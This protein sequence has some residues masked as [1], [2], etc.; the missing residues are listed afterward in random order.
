MSRHPSVTVVV[1]CTTEMPAAAIAGIRAQKRVRPDLVVVRLAGVSHNVDHEV[2]LADDS[3]TIPSLL[4]LASGEFIVLHHP[5]HRSLPDRV[6]RQLECLERD[7][8]SG[9]A[10]GNA[11]VVNGDTVTTWAVADGS[12]ALHERRLVREHHALLGAT[13]MIRR[14]VLEEAFRHGVTTLDLAFWLWAAT[15]TRTRH[16]GDGALIQVA[17]TDAPV[18]TLPGVVETPRAVTDALR[19]HVARRPLRDLVP[20]LDWP[21]LHPAAAERAALTRLAAIIDARPVAAPGLADA[22]RDRAGRVPEAPA[23]RRTRGRLLMT[24]YGFNDSGG[25]TTI[26]RLAA[27][28]LVRRGW[29]VTVF[30]AATAQRPDLGPY[31]TDEWEEDGVRLVG[32]FNRPH[33]FG[34]IGNPDREVDDPAITAAFDRV[35]QRVRPDVAHLHNLHNLGAGLLDV[36]SAHGV[37]AHFTTHNYWLLCPRTYLFGDDLRLCDGPAVD[38]AICASCVGSRDVQGHRRRFLGIRDRFTRAI[39]SCHAVSHAVR[40]N[41]IAHGYDPSHLDVV[42]Q[43]VPAEDEAWETVGRHRSPGRVNPDQLTVGFV[44]SVY[45][46]KGAHVLVRAAQQVRGDL[47]VRIHGEIPAAVA[48]QLLEIDERGC[49]ELHGAFSP[50]ELPTILQD[51]DVAALPSVWWDCAPL[52]AGEC[53]AAGVPVLAPRMG[54]LAEAIRDGVD[55]L[56]FEGA[57]HE[58]LAAALTRLVSEADLLPRLQ[59]GIEP[60]RGFATWIDDLEAAYAGMRPGRVDQADNA[61]PTAVRWVGD[62]QTHS[63]LAHI[64]REVCAR[65]EEDPSVNLQIVAMD[66]DR[67]PGPLPH[68]PEVEVRHSWPPRFD[69]HG[70]GRLALIQPWEY[71][72]IPR[73]WLEPLRNQVDELWVPSEFVRTMYLQAGVPGDRVVVVPNGVDLDLLDPS[74]PKYVPK[75]LREDATRFLFLGGVIGRKGPDVLLEAWARAFTPDDAV[76]LIIKD[77]G[78]GTFYRG[79]RTELHDAAEDPSN[80][81]ILHLTDDLSDADIA[82]LYRSAHVLVHPYRGEGFAMPVLE[83]MA[84]G[85]PTIIT[86]GGPTDEFCPDDACWRIRSEYTERDQ[87]RFG[88]DLILDG[89]VRVLEPETDHLVEL[90]RAVHEAGE[91]ER[92]RR[93]RAART[94]AEH[95]GWDDITRRYRE[96]IDVLR[97]LPRRT[98]ASA[99][100]AAGV[101]PRVL[102]APA[103]RRGGI[104]LAELLEAWNTWT[105]PGTLVLLSCSPADGENADLEGAVMEG[106]RLAGLDLEHCP[107]M[108]IQTARG[109][110]DYAETLLRDCAGYVAVNGGAPGLERAARRLGVPVVEVQD[111][112]QIAGVARKAA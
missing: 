55:G 49:V 64:N 78:N 109:E 6:A 71:G 33:G 106:A 100:R 77:V 54:G 20:E 99:T 37:P 101:A 84:A 67:M 56:S 24:S 40:R 103:W 69:P 27:K 73:D 80:A 15:A 44:G 38:G 41:L 88:D 105:G 48:Q 74:G 23:P 53:L 65:L 9:I 86:A 30:H 25:G 81:P 29:D 94:A 57:N 59:S 93:G 45:P 46:H 34:D 104:A 72:A 112:G 35:V 102:A 7:V 17:S 19:A 47:R 39:T 1:P 28:E 43:C 110:T 36:C 68:A 63:S 90:L 16:S 10:H 52:A 83:A 60:P 2:T 97:R 8:E 75:G 108:V 12:P 18:L 89:Y 66:S 85:L 111:L 70:A 51:I 26:P 13:A 82:G 87:D 21:V 32:V 61:I 4:D 11:E 76:Q 98:P 31:G 50:T 42:R 95:Y 5:G 79:S 14:R 3:L 22:L 91:D 96:R 58:Q 107:D 62:Q 92:M